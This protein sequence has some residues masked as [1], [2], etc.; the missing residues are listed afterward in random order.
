MQIQFTF[1][2]DK[3]Y[4]PFGFS[5]KT[6]IPVPIIFTL[7]NLASV[8]MANI[9]IFDTSMRSNRALLSKRNLKKLLILLVKYRATSYMMLLLPCSQSK[10]C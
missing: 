6:T 10:E 5:Y 7:D 1:V 3:I 2:I 4:L 8:L 9:F